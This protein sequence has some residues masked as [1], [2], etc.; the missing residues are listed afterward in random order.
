[1]GTDGPGI[2][3]KI[4]ESF[5]RI[6][7][8]FYPPGNSK[9]KSRKKS[10]SSSSSSTKNVKETGRQKDK[11]SKRKHAFKGAMHL[12]AGG[13]EM[14]QSKYYDTKLNIRDKVD[15]MRN[16][17]KSSSSSSSSKDRHHG[18]KPLSQSRR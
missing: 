4:K 8:K 9:D 5:N 15:K 2:T 12:A 14:V 7:D 13:K 16:K 1:M 11:R 17:K 10:Q 18:S 6:K 3:D